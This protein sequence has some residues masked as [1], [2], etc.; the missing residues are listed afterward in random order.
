LIDFIRDGFI[1]IKS[2]KSELKTEIKKN[3]KLK[4][5]LREKAKSPS[6]V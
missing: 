2:L 4:T 5:I 3:I 6:R 1:K